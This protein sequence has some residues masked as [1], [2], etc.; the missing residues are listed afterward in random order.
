MN[1]GN[2]DRILFWAIA[3]I[4]GFPSLIV[5]LGELIHRL[6]RQDKPLAATLRIIRDLVLPVLV[7]MLFMQHVLQLDPDSNLIKGIETLFWVCLIHAALSLL[8]TVLFEQADS[9]TWRS[10]VPKLLIDISRLFLILVGSAIVLATVWNADLAG[11]ATALGVSSIV[12][13]LAL[14][15]TLGS[16]MSGIALLFERPFSV[17][18]W[19]RVGDVAGQVIDINWRSVRLQTL[20]REMVV[21]PH[22]V[23]SNEIVRNFSQPLRIHAERFRIGF[24]YKDPPNLAK[25]VLK[26]TALATQGILSNPEPQVFT[27]SYDDFAINYE[28]KFFIQDYANFEEIRDTF[29]TRVWYAAQRNDLMIPFPI[30]TLYHYHGPTS[31]AKGLSKKVAESLQSIPSFVPL[32]KESNNLQTFSQGIV[33]QHF[34]TGEYVVKQG[35]LGHSLYI[36]VSGQAILSVINDGGEEQEMLPLKA[37]E[38]FGEMALFSGEPSAVS[39]IAVGDIEVMSLSLTVVNEMIER[40][41]SFAREI[42]QILEIRRRLINGT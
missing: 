4:V 12:I 27:L 10:R 37:G 7:F 35:D 16:V 9:D 29:V 34:G 13:A 17:G 30:R 3:L 21:I 38:F 32:D 28:V 24:S 8:N 5:L 41:P 2:P 15:D 22:K 42:G 19:L 33:L 11:L 14:Q 40:Q 18:D 26:S 36:I 1:N 39:V 6:K 25:Q 31:Q 20:E 23:I